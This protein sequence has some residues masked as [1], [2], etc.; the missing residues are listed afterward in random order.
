MTA[1][2]GNAGLNLFEIFS[3]ED[4]Y[5]RNITRYFK[6]G[7]LQGDY[8]DLKDNIDFSAWL[9]Y[10]A[11]GILNELRRVI[12]ILP[13]QS[14]AKPRLESHHQQILDYTHQRG[15]IAQREYGDI[16]DRSLASRKLYFEKLIQLNLIEVNGLGRS[17]YY[18]LSPPQ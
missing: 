10:F 17:T 15:S 11:E 13:E 8:Y 9:E 16:S 4:Y 5:N 7:G 1:I 3:F 18:V 6:M 2:L 12:K 14:Q